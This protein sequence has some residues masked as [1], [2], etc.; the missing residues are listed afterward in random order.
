MNLVPGA[1]QVFNK[2]SEYGQINEWEWRGM[3]SNDMMLK[4]VDNRKP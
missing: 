2:Y 4:W 1:E 3:I